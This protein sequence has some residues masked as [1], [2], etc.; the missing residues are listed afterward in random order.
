MFAAIK[1][2]WVKALRSERYKQTTSV[3]QDAEGKN[4]C[5]GV[6]IRVQGGKVK[7]VCGPDLDRIEKLQRA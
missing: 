4:C 3:L 7:K 6:L 1:A 5:L 2:K